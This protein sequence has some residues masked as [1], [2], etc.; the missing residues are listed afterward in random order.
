M[1]S[2]GR[3]RNLSFFAFTATPKA[4]TLE[5]F[6][7]NKEPFH[8]YSMRQAIEEGY[9][10]D[11]LKHYTTY[12][13]FFQIAKKVTDDPTHKKKKAIKRLAKFLALHPVNISQKT[14]IIIEHFRATVK[15]KINGRAK[16]M[17]VTGSRLHA[18][19]Y[20]LA[21]TRYI[22]ENGYD[23]V[24][25][26]VAFSGKVKDPDTGLEYSEPGMNIDPVNGKQISEK[27]LPEKFDTMD[28]QIL[29]VANKYQTG[30]DQ[31]L[32]FAMYVDNR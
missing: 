13:S 11:V 12:K 17:V 4:K 22:A 18:V 6:G 21:F 14:E 15:D 25:P 3:Q 30:F 20:M 29:L 19:R 31:P 8:I 27:E 1:E 10:K 26:V 32:L 9:I 16:A 5:I 7:R 2:R 23:D 24:N 28:Y